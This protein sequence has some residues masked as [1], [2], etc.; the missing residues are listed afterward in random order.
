MI[1]FIYSELIIVECRKSYIDCTIVQCFNM[2]YYLQGI[3][4]SIKIN[5]IN[6]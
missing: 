3:D 4:N 6:K 5:K 2:H 1:V